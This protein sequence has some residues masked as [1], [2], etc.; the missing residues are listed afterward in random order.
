MTGTETQNDTGGPRVGLFFTCLVDV[1]RPNVVF[2]AVK[3]LRE[4]GCIVEIPKTQTCC[5]QPAFNSGD[6]KDARVIAKAV[7]EAF[8]GFDY[9]VAPSG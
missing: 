2:A 4:A 6:V 9:V 7:I 1:F 5:G 3:L 8:D